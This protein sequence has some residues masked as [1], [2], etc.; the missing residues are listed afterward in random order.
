V[1][2]EG[3]G[4]SGWRLRERK[5]EAAAIGRSQGARARVRCWASS[6]PIRIGFVL[7]YFSFFRISFYCNKTNIYILSKNYNKS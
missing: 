5:H 4:E 6:G 1:Q 2:R 3:R 7:F